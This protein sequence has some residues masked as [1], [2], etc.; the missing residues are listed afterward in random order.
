MALYA[1]RTVDMQSNAVLED[2]DLQDVEFS[3]KLS[4]VGDLSGTLFVPENQRG[5]LLDAATVPG[6]TG[7][8]VLRNGVPVWG[9]IIWKRDWDETTATFRLSCGS[10]ESYA[11][12]ILQLNN[13]AYTNTDQFTIARQLLSSNGVDTE[14]G[15]SWPTVALSGF[16]RKRNM[17]S[18]EYKSV[19][20]ELEQLAGLEK[21]FDYTV[22]SYVKIDGSFGRRYQFGYPRLGRTASLSP[23]SNSLT[24]DYPGNLAPFQVGED[25]EGGATSLFAIGSGEGQALLVAH[26]GDGTLGTGPVPLPTQA[27][28]L[29]RN[30][31]D[32]HG[33]VNGL[34]FTWPG[35]PAIVA[36]YGPYLS[37]EAIKDDSGAITTTTTVTGPVPE[38]TQAAQLIRDRMQAGLEIFEDWSWSGMPAIVGKYND[39]LNNTY[40]S[41][42]RSLADIPESI[43]WLSQYID[44]HPAPEQ[45]QWTGLDWERTKTWLNDYIASHPAAYRFNPTPDTI[46][47]PWPRLDATV[48][49]KSVVFMSTLQSHA[50]EDLKDLLPPIDAWTFQLAPDSDVKL[51]DIKIGDSAVF[52]LTSRRWKDPKIF[53]R[54]ITEIR[55]RPGSH[56]TLEVV[57]LG[58]SE[59]RTG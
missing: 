44:Q 47:G 37:N 7:L 29:I 8:Y 10:W 40:T 45:E 20:L 52:R 51:T 49:Y 30:R 9:G 11:Y 58:I 16:S 34:W 35:A 6:R 42:G 54:R 46:Y 55:V 18:Y 41:S 12:H 57:Q 39:S 24:F 28:T 2:I 1:Y 31:V 19:G 3:I 36:T 26:A 23:S 15:I 4:G 59:E 56:G 22:E 32:S 53:I 17:Y 38:A 13:L 5:L 50:N 25:A 43:I 21:G 27:A 48:S 14:S 33:D